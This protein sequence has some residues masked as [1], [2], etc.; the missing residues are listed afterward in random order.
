MNS[1]CINNA[2]CYALA[3]K[4]TNSSVQRVTGILNDPKITAKEVAA[5]VEIMAAIAGAIRELGSI[6]SGN[7]YGRIMSK[8]S[9][10]LY[11]G[12]IETLQ[13]VGLIKKE[14][15]LLIWIGGE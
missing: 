6:P 11:T 7:L 15:D 4:E 3:M 5:S 9:F 1:S 12:S 14:N 8:L 10:E 13:M 2:T